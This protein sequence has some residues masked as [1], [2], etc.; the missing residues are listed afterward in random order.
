MLPRALQTRAVLE[1][2]GRAAGDAGIPLNR[3][4]VGSGRNA[5]NPHTGSPEFFD[6]KDEDQME[7]IVVTAPRDSGVNTSPLAVDEYG[8]SVE[9]I[10]NPDFQRGQGEALI[11][12]LP[13]VGLANASGYSFQWEDGDG[14][15]PSSIRKH[16]SLVEN[17][18]KGDYTAASLS[19]LGALGDVAPALAPSLKAA[20]ATEELTPLLRDALNAPFNVGNMSLAD[21]SYFY[22]HAKNG[23]H[24]TGT[25]FDI[26]PVRVDGKNAGTDFTSADYDRAAT[27]RLVDTLRETGGVKEIL[28]D[29]PEIQGVRTLGP[30][31]PHKNHLHVQVDPNWRRPSGR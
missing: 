25:A 2:L 29:D 11:N 5:I 31:S 20:R 6:P 17:L 23:D 13:G 18:S 10:S 1:A 7:E 9:D 8:R 28:F 24:T 14:F 21:G 15:L 19:G 4:R 30:K 22:P 26:R 12:A 27:Q 3:L 16:P